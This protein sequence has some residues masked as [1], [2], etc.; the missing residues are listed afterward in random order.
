[1]PSFAVSVKDQVKQSVDIV[2]LVGESIAL[3]RAG[4]VYKG[5]CPFHDDHRP[6]LTVD[7]DRQSFKCW[8]CG[9]GGDVISFV[10]EQERVDFVEAMRIL[11]Q[12]AG[13][14]I[15]HQSQSTEDRE[16]SLFYEVM[17]WAETEFQRCLRDRSDAS[18]VREYL[19]ERG[20]SEESQDVFKLGYH[21]QEWEW[22][23]SRAAKKKWTPRLLEQVG[24]VKAR[25]S[26]KGYYDRF[27]G[28]LMFPIHDNRGRTVAFGA[29]I[30]PG[31]ERGDAPKY[32]NSPETPLFVK[33]EM[34]YGFALAR[35][36]IVRSG[37]GVMVEGYTDC[38]L[39]HQAGQKNVL[40]PLGTALTERHVQLMKRHAKRAVLVFDGDD[41][42][43]KAAIRAI[44]V[45]LSHDMEIRLCS[46]PE[47]QDPCNVIRD[48]GEAAFRA[49]VDGAEDALEFYLDTLMKRFDIST[50]SGKYAISQELAAVLTRAPR[51]VAGYDVNRQVREDLILGRMS[52]RL[53][54]PETSLRSTITTTRGKQRVQTNTR[55]IHQESSSEDPIET[56]LIE[57]IIQ[58]PALIKS[59]SEEVRPESLVDEELRI[60]YETCIALSD[61]GEIPDF[62]RLMTEFE[63]QKLKQRLND[64]EESGRHKGNT[65]QRYEAFVVQLKCR[66]E[67]RN[68][69]SL[70][71]QLR[72]TDSDDQ[73]ELLRQ[74]HDSKRVEY[75]IK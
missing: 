63:D 52:H 40:A 60:L 2:A 59:L 24:L 21:P 9:K 48:Q 29:R 18:V 33:R 28:R 49:Y 10:Q 70:K 53:G 43:Q 7:P 4:R 54:I 62:D 72:E 66:R 68:R 27:V 16:K 1:M 11:G 74:L 47:G 57:I 12:R 36:D 32:L 61:A 6:S 8:S 13:I 5:L 37:V 46:L 34:L 51:T 73:L 65:E 20:I 64:L 41:A 15:D 14:Q 58:D 50:T 39:A 42:G 71:E 3:Q 44:D 30:L 75:K 17:A 35:G 19:H 56:E 38:I 23:L 22:L 25:D 55:S 31:S 67:N 45:F 26:G 69:H